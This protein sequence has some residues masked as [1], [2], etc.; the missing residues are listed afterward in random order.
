MYSRLSLL[1]A[2]TF[3]LS[4]MVSCTDDAEQGNAEAAME[5][6]LIRLHYENTGGEKGVT[7]FGYDSDGRQRNAIWELLDGS[8]YSINL[9]EYDEDDRLIRKYREFSDSLTSEELYVYDDLGNRT[10]ESFSRSDGISGTAT[11]EYDQAGHPTRAVCVGLKGWFHGIL[12]YTCDSNGVKT[13]ASISKE[14]KQIGS[15]E[16]AYD[17]HGNLTREHWDFPERWSQTFT[18]EYDSTD[19]SEPL[20]FTSSNALLAN[21]D[22]FRLSEEKYD[23]SGTI[24]GP[25]FFVYDDEG[26]LTTKRFERSDGFSTKTT[27]LY[28]GRG[29]L[30]KSYR[31]YSNGLSAIFTYDFNE[32]RKL[33]SRSFIKSDGTGGSE[34]YEYDE[35]PRLIR[36][37]YDKFDSWMTGS[38][39]FSH[40]PDGQLT[41]GLYH[42]EEGWEA[43]ILFD[44]DEHGNLVRVHWAFPEDKY[45]TYEFE[46]ETV[47]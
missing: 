17:S 36:A 31:Q 42:A 40:G 6:R 41:K 20:R 15:I 14:G 5:Y 13:S 35:Q 47:Q 9:C 23:Y 37:D 16:Y 10:S 1:L 25:S 28:D 33:V 3:L 38:I 27:F 4:T 29:N 18:Y 43:D 2:A 19:R 46:Y 26:K 24:G 22:G 32:Q 12:D 44:Y 21:I 45:Q 39:A 8:R 11:Y 30:T 34:S 7:T